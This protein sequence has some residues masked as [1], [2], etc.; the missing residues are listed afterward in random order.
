M[1]HKLKL[2]MNDIKCACA[3]IAFAPA[4]YAIGEVAKAKRTYTPGR[5]A[6]ARLRAGRT[7][8]AEV[9]F[10]YY[11]ELRGR[12]QYLTKALRLGMG[13]GVNFD[14]LNELGAQALGLPLTNGGAK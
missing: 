9:L 12:F 2:D 8:I 3:A 1:A 5:Y 13:E 11:P 14:E 7:A 10:L 4:Q 6:Q